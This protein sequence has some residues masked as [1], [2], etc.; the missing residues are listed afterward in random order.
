L[1]RPPALAALLVLSALLHGPLP[2]AAQ[3]AHPGASA[4]VWVDTLVVSEGD[5]QGIE[6]SFGFHVLATRGL[7]RLLGEL[8][9]PP[10]PPAGSLEA[11]LSGPLLVDG[12]YFELRPWQTAHPDTFQIDLRRAEE[13]AALTLTWDKARLASRT[14]L[15]RLEDPFGGLVG[16]RVDMHAVS[17]MELTNSALRAVKLIVQPAEVPPGPSVV[18]QQTWGQVKHGD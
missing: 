2:A 17:R 14:R 3:T 8:A 4:P 16:V 13:G 5:Q 15:A 11:R 12:V 6:L 9:L 1:A 7:D 18:G 10:Y